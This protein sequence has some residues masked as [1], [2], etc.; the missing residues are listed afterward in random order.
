MSVTAAPPH[1]AVPAAIQ[2]ELSQVATFRRFSVAEYHEMIRTVMLTTEDRVELIYG[3]LVNKTPQNDPHASTIGRLSEDLLRVSP[4]GW[5][6]HIQLPITLSDGEPEPDAAVVRGDRRTCDHRK[7][8]GT[9][10]GV[11]VEVADSTLRFDRRVKRA[12]YATAAIPVHWIVNLFD[13]HVEVYTDPD[14]AADPPAY[15]TRT[16]FPPGRSVPLVLDGRPVATLPVAEP[17]PLSPP[18]VRPRTHP[19]PA[20]HA[21]QRPAQERSAARTRRPHQAGGGRLD[22]PRR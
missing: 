8:N 10:F 19:R 4:A 2:A 18:H 7:P 3:Y 9:D 13:G 1:P 15:R 11:V 21:R 17:P 5:R 20:R 14:P 6:V 22:R 16:D 12:Q